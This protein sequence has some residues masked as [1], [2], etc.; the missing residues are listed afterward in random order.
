MVVVENRTVQLAEPAR[1]SRADSRGDDTIAG[2]LLGG[3]PP[4]KKP[5]PDLFIKCCLR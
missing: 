1:A 4:C 2:S 3:F 5:V